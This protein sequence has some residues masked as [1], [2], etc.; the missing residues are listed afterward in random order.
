MRP[1]NPETGKPWPRKKPVDWDSVRSTLRY[2]QEDKRLRDAGFTRIS[3]FAA[4][5]WESPMCTHLVTD[6]VVAHG[7]R[8]VYVRTTQRG[9]G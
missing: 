6:A 4:L 3:A 8:S 5:S 2:R 9:R 1:F 7:G